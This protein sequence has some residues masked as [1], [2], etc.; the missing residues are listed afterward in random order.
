MLREIAAEE[1]GLTLRVCLLY[2]G[3]RVVAVGT[4][5]PTTCLELVCV[6]VCG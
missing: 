5:V 6:S 4:D 1:V 3:G 2:L